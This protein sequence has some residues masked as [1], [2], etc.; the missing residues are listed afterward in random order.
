MPGTNVSVN[1]A[2]GLSMSV[3][4]VRHRYGPRWKAWSMMVWY[5]SG[6]A[7][8]NANTR[9]SG[10]KCTGSV[11]IRASPALLLLLLPCL[12]QP[13]PPRPPSCRCFRPLLLR[14]LLLSGSDR[15]WCTARCG[16]S[17]YQTFKSRYGTDCVVLH[18]SWYKL[19]GTAQCLVQ[20]VSYDK[21]PGTDI[22]RDIAY[23]TSRCLVLTSRNSQDLEG[24]WATARIKPV[25]NQVSAY[26][27]ATRCPVL[28]SCM[29]A[30]AYGL[31]TRCPVLS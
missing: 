30:S 28:T 8:S 14:L 13:G 27:L 29:A 25:M 21:V 6:P 24:I 4:N 16:L 23:R 10:T 1:S 11:V 22:P 12:I 19:C 18:N 20:T 5:A 2:L 31:A 26:G 3:T 7:K 9:V 15:V 17:E